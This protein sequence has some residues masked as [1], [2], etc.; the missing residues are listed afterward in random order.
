MLS[1]PKSF[2]VPSSP[3]ATPQFQSIQAWQR[4]EAKLIRT[5]ASYVSNS[6]QRTMKTRPSREHW[7]QP[8]QFLF[9]FLVIAILQFMVPVH[10]GYQQTMPGKDMR[11]WRFW[12]TLSCSSARTCSMGSIIYMHVSFQT[13]WYF[14]TGHT[15]SMRGGDDSHLSLS[16]HS[17]LIKLA[18]QKQSNP[19]FPVQLF[20]N[21]ITF[22]T[23][24]SRS[25]PECT[26]SSDALA[27]ADPGQRHS[28][29]SE[30]KGAD[31]RTINF[32]GPKPNANTWIHC[33]R[34]ICYSC[35]LWLLFLWCLLITLI[36]I[37]SGYLW[38]NR[39]SCL[40]WHCLPYLIYFWLHV[41]A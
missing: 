36:H 13:L 11:R 1:F 40:S 20:T 24:H 3:D 8:P 32:Q 35:L 6:F 41:Y 37:L 14:V 26:K 10:N 33:S 4:V 19:H 31:S 5:I 30:Q 27:P 7:N 28:F 12:R 38:L 15:L 25:Y 29:T 17:S 22:E 34:F 9:V 21:L 23:L 16:S 18:H 2:H 39:C